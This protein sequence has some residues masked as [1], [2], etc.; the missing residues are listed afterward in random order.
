[1]DQLITAQ[2]S[3]Q[4]TVATEPIIWSTQSDNYFMITDNYRQISNIS[5]TKSQHLNVSSLVL[6]LSLPNPLKPGVK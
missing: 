4:I 6:Q 3:S 1:M 2:F 5:R